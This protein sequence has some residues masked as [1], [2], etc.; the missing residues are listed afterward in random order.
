MWMSSRRKTIFREAPYPFARSLC[1]GTAA[2]RLARRSNDP[3]AGVP[4]RLAKGRPRRPALRTA[5]D[6]P[7]RRFPLRLGTPVF[8]NS[9]GGRVACAASITMSWRSDAAFAGGVSEPLSFSARGSGGE[10]S[11]LASDASSA[12]DGPGAGAVV[13]CGPK[14]KRAANAMSSSA[15]T[16]RP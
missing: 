14:T 10:A 11:E 15:T 3:C 1:Q 8:D 12:V 4:G 2:L 16:D 9:P 7:C 6:L 5:P 13:A